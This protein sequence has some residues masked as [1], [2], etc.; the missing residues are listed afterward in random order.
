MTDM[1]REQFSAYYYSFMATGEPGVDAVLRA[2]AKAGKAYHHTERWDD[3]YDEDGPTQVDLIQSAADKAA[4]DAKAAIAAAF[5]SGMD[6][7]IDGIEQVSYDKGQRDM[8]AKCIEV[9]EALPPIT[10]AY[11]TSDNAGGQGLAIVTRTWLCNRDAALAA[12]RALEEK[13]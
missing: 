1:Q 8:L 5:Q 13:P 9:V 6:Q 10:D 4:A 3:D 11:G 7:M 12:L 2:V